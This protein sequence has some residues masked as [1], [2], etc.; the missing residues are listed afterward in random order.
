[1]GD[2]QGREQDTYSMQVIITLRRTSMLLALYTRHIRI[3]STSSPIVDSFHLVVY[4]IG[5]GICY[6][7][8]WQLL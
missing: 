8:K 4:G 3:V 2:K 1:M 6:E 7:M 5:G